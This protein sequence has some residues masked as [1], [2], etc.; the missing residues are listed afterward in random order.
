MKK[1]FI[2]IFLF[3]IAFNVKAEEVNFAENAKSAILM[4]VSTGKIIFSKN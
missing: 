1:I 2:F 3:L 4:E